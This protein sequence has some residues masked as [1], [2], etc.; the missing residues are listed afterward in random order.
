MTFQVYVGEKLFALRKGLSLTQEDL[1]TLSGLST[2][3][4]QDL[5]AGKKQASVVTIF[6]LAKAL[7][8]IP[9]DLLQDAWET[10]LKHE[11]Y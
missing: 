7:D 10:F 8:V 1:A 2:R 3:F 11:P 9:Q 5:E 6:K 4:L